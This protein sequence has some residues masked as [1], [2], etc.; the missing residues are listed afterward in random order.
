MRAV[1]RAS[2]GTKDQVDGQDGFLEHRATVFS[3]RRVEQPQRGQC[4]P[5]LGQ[6]GGGRASLHGDQGASVREQ[7][8]ALAG[9]LVEPGHSTRCHPW[10]REHTRELLGSATVHGHIVEMKCRHRLREPF[11]AAQHRL[12][13]MHVE[14]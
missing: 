6:L 2:T 5:V 12:D 3:H 4:R 14:V 11:R 8:H 13:Q 7:G 10:G 1:R 9:E